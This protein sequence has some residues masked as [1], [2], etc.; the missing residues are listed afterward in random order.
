MSIKDCATVCTEIV[1]E[2]IQKNLINPKKRED[3]IKKLQSGV[4]TSEEWTLLA[5][6]VTEDTTNA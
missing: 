1:D 2:F 3:I 5:E 4:M 6:L